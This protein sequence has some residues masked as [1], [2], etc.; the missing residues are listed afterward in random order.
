MSINLHVLK[1]TSFSPAT[2]WRG[3]LASPLAARV[4]RNKNKIM[5]N[6]PNFKNTIMNVR[7]Y[8]TKDYNNFLTFYRRKNKAKQSQN[9]PN[10]LDDQMNVTTSITKDNE[11]FRPFSRRKNKAK[12]SQFKPN[13]DPIL[14]LFS[15]F[16]L[17]NSPAMAING[18]KSWGLNKPFGEI[19]KRYGCEYCSKR[20]DYLRELKAIGEDK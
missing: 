19:E 5:Q 20:A 17:C 2:C 12:Q 13:F 1:A 15:Q 8:I 14:A 6:K 9:K 18:Y 11:I 3:S 7:T 10:L 4:A 16:W